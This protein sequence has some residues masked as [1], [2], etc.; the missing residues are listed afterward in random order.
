MGCFQAAKVRLVIDLTSY[1]EQAQVIYVDI[2]QHS[3]VLPLVW[4]IMSGQTKWDQRLWECIDLIFQRL[5]PYLGKTDCT[6]MRESAFGCFPMVGLC[7]KEGWH[8]VFSLHLAPPFTCAGAPAWLSTS[9]SSSYCSRKLMTGGLV[10]F[11]GWQ[12]IL[13]LGSKVT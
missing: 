11:T 5:A 8:D 4:K 3:H 13:P 6:I 7:Q 2:L 10:L 12:G 1:E 9:T